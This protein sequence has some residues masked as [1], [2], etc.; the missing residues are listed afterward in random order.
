ML[1]TLLPGMKPRT[2]GIR[3]G[4]GPWAYLGVLEKLSLPAGIKTHERAIRIVFAIP[5]K[6]FKLL[7]VVR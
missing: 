2:H 1:A 5:T 3:G 4:V 7:S 6:L